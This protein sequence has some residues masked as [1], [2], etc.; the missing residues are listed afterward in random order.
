[1]VD[2]T[3]PRRDVHFQALPHR[4][5]TVRGFLAETA[6]SIAADIQLLLM[7]ILQPM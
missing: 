6:R 3:F 1:M 5:H 4:C 7:I 2:M